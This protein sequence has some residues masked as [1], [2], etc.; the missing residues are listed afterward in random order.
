[1]I[2]KAPIIINDKKVWTD[3]KDIDFDGSDFERIGIEF[4][5]ETKCTRKGKVAN[6]TALLIPQRELVDYVT[7]WITINRK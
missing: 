2:C 6:T 1:V 7:K 5:Y 4:M 3:F